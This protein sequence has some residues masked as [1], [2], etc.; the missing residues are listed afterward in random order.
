VPL[1]DL[2]TLSTVQGSAFTR[3]ERERFELVAHLPAAVHSLE[4]QAK[5]ALHQLE[6]KP[7]PLAQHT[8]LV[9]LREQNEVRAPCSSSSL[10]IAR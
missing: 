9:S 1:T 3:E 6:Q 10:S 7:D 5:R 4:L 8:F 2:P